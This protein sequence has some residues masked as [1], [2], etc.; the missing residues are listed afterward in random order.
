MEARVL[1]IRRLSVGGLSERCLGIGLAVF[2]AIVAALAKGAVVILSAILVE[3]RVASVA[4]QQGVLNV[5]C[6]C[7][8]EYCVTPTGSLREATKK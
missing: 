4:S 3:G 2:R 5:H 7:H 6:G 1:S 8:D